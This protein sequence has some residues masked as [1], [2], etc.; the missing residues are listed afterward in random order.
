MEDAQAS[1]A[2][3]ED[4]QAHIRRSEIDVRSLKRH[5]RHVLAEV[6]QA[7]ISQVLHV[8]PAEQGLG[9]VIGYIQLAVRHGVA[10]QQR[11]SVRWQG[12][13]GIWRRAD[14]PLFYFTRERLHELG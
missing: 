11:E 5:I 7:S 6:S 2:R 3:I 14:A 8:C 13:D 9:S 4:I 10:T 1:D 12:L